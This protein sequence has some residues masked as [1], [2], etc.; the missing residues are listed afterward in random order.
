M[1]ANYITIGSRFRP[2]SYEELIAPL[3]AAEQEHQRQEELYNT[4]SDTLGQIG[5]QL[6]REYDQDVLDNI[7]NPYRSAL[8]SAAEELASKGLT[9]GSRRTLN[10]LRRQ[11]NNELVPVQQ[12]ILARAEARKLWDERVA[13]D[14]TL[15]TNANPYYQ[16]VDAY[17]NGMSPE[18]AYVSGNE[19]YGRGQALSQAFSEVM[20]S[21]PEDAQ[22]AL[23][24]QYWQIVSQYGPTSEEARQFMEGVLESIPALNNQIEEIMDN[25]GIY[26]E[27][28]TVSDQDRARRY[29]VEGMMAGLSGD[30]KVQYLN[31]QAYGLTGEAPEVPKVPETP[32]QT[33]SNMNV[34][35]GAPQPT[36]KPKKHEQAVADY[37]AYSGFYTGDQ[38]SDNAYVLAAVDGEEMLVSPELMAMLVYEEQ[39]EVYD[40][41]RREYGEQL[42]QEHRER[43]KHEFGMY[44]EE[45]SSYVE[46]M[47]DE[48]IHAAV[49]QQVNARYPKYSE[50]QLRKT[51]E[52][53]RKRFNALA[54]KYSYISDDPITNVRLGSVIQLSQ[55]QDTPIRFDFNRETSAGFTINDKNWQNKILSGRVFKYN[56]E[57][58]TV[59]KQISAETKK[60]LLDAKNR[61]YSIDKKGRVLVS[62]G[63]NFYYLEGSAADVLK[64]RGVQARMDAL[65]DFSES[66]YNVDGISVPGIGTSADRPV[67][68]VNLSPENWVGYNVFDENFTVDGVSI[69]S[70][71]AESPGNFSPVIA[72]GNTI[73]YVLAVNDSEGVPHKILITETGVCIGVSNPYSFMG[74]DATALLEDMI[75]VSYNTEKE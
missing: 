54:E 26:S 32:V 71:L 1:A 34:Y 56:P 67:L 63:E 44:P 35:P 73:G 65:M 25:S 43:F 68:R 5:G 55:S 51:K 16:G 58:Q 62:D 28:F 2:F 48:G 29:I 50:R 64:Q 18:A 11:F 39:P 24:G 21:V 59:E 7:Y 75:D 52:R 47:N 12:G 40:E 6:S 27:G 46:V 69:G 49:L 60:N 9:S 33:P 57:T 53:D 30:T 23:E 42:W 70:L 20:R 72:G 36:V 8:E 61:Y 38:N 31:N 10:A 45:Q 41:M 4:Y 19:L 37:E 14:P 66:G 74:S 17:M 13:K 3:V 15:M 22:L